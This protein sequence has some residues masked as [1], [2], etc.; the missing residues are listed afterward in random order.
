LKNKSIKQKIK[1]KKDFKN[2]KNENNDLS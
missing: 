1:N 2:V